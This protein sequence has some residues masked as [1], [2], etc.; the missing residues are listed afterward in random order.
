MAK[1]NW[2]HP[3]QSNRYSQLFW[4]KSICYLF[5]LVMKLRD[6]VFLLGFLFDV[7]KSVRS[8]VVFFFVPRSRKR[9]AKT[10]FSPW[11][12]DKGPD[13]TP[14]HIEYL[15]LQII[16]LQTTFDHNCTLSIPYCLPG[17]LK[18]LNP[19]FHD[20]ATLLSQPTK[21]RQMIMP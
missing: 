16:A 9:L 1:Q 18:E 3:H 20:L 4:Q 15:L 10:T 7:M 13:S 12:K 8:L 19:L 5:L 21:S 11:P 6:T 2:I 14:S 17:C